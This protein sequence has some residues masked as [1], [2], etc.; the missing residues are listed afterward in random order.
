MR[1][2]LFLQTQ[3]LA[4]QYGSFKIKQWGQMVSEGDWKSEKSKN[5]IKIYWETSRK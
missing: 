2:L 3:I 5:K 4:P 1:I